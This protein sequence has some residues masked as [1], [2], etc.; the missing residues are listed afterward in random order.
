MGTCLNCTK[1]KMHEVIKLHENKIARS[2][3]CTKPKLHEGTKLHEDDFAP[4]VNFARVTFL[5]V[6]KKIKKNKKLTEKKLKNY[7]IK[8][9]VTDRG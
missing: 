5:H 2:Q 1:T 8:K 6:S 3:I 7:L 9:K 4:R